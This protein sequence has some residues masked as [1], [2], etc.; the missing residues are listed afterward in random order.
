MLEMPDVYYLS[1]WGKLNEVLEN[2]IYEEF[3]FQSSLGKIVYP[4]IKRP[5]PIKVDGVQYFD[6]ITPYGFN[7][8]CIIECSGNKEDL[9]TEYTNAFNN[10]CKEKNIISEYVRFSPWLNN[11]QDFSNNYELCDNNMT[12]FIDLAKGDYFE[13][14]FDSK[15]RNQ[16]RKAQKTGVKIEFDFDGKMLDVFF[17]LYEKMI[18]K[19]NVSNYYRF[20]KEFIENTFE[21]IKG[22]IF[23]AVAFFGDIPISAAMFMFY[24]DKVHYHLSG[25]DREYSSCCGNHLLL[26]SVADWSYNNGYKTLHLGGIS[27]DNIGL[28]N[29]KKG[30]AK[31][32]EL[33][34]FVGKRI[35]NDKIYNKIVEQ[36]AT[37]NSSYFPQYRG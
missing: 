26:S 17:E 37:E 27:K 22:N 25:N 8:P 31:D 6:I 34:F 5:T 7:G 32:G 36:S 15:C 2:G 21:R 28:Y 4:Y 1:Q 10:Y 19:N 33:K 12:L 29:F 13:K 24:G 18:E 9:L 35:D 14:C 30:F 3:F 20:S 16:I 23:I 11:A